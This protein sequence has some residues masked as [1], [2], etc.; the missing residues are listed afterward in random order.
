MQKRIGHFSE[1]SPA[2]IDIFPRQEKEFSRPLPDRVSGAFTR[3]THAEIDL[4]SASQSLGL[5]LLLRVALGKQC[6]QDVR[7][8]IDES[9]T[10]HVCR[11]IAAP[12]IE[13]CQD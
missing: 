1:I 5:R 10:D 11:E 13:S 6:R 9:V 4:V 8:E 3:Y 12:Q 2:K 7:N